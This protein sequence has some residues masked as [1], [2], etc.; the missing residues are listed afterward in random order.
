MSRMFCTTAIS[1]MN[2]STTTFWKD[3]GTCMQ[4]QA[5]TLNTTLMRKAQIKLSRVLPARQNSQ[6]HINQVFLKN[7]VDKVFFSKG[8]KLE[9][10]GITQWKSFLRTDCKV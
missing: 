6:G 10:L 5:L 9:I 4:L 3:D 8:T 1:N 2:F 7:N